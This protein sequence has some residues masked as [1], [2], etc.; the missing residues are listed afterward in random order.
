MTT[1]NSIIETLA[2]HK[3]RLSAKY[4]MSRIAVFGSY[5]RNQQKLNSDVDVMVE[6]KNPVGIEFIDLAEE[7]ENILNLKVDLVSKNAIREN[8]L[9]DI[10]SEL[11][12][13]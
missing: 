8:Y 12:Y 6:F 11:R 9:I 5:A 2:S 13:V 10:E 7:L 4:G 1:L 3:Q